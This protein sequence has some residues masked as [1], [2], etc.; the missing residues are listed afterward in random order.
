[1]KKK[2]Q[3]VQSACLIAS[4]SNGHFAS[5]FG[6]AGKNCWLRDADVSCITIDR[7]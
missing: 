1:M 7:K 2:K 5:N 4:K 3:M 6:N